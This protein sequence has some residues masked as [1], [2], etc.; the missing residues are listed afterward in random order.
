MKMRDSKL[1]KGRK[2]VKAWKALEEEVWSEWERFGK[3][4]HKAIKREIE[5]NEKPDHTE[6]IYKGLVNLDR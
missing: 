3:R 2:L 5:W 4:E 6:P 1:T